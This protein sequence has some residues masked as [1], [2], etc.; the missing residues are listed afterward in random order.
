M[1]LICQL[2]KDPESNDDA[3]VHGT[4]VK[5]RGNVSAVDQGTGRGGE[6]ASERTWS[7]IIDETRIDVASG[8]GPG[9]AT[10][11]RRSAVTR[12]VTAVTGRKGSPISGRGRLKL[13][14]SPLTVS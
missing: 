10:T 6:V 5:G 7:A 13:K 4:G 14:R 1:V 11:G 12:T 9:I 2:F 3:V 8:L